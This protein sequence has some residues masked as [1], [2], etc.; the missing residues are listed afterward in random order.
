MQVLKNS[1]GA[2]WGERGFFR[3]LRGADAAGVESMAEEARVTPV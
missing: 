2:G 1:W 3:V